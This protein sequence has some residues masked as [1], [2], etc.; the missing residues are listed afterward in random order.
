MK[1]TKI[2]VAAYALVASFGAMAATVC[3][4]TTGVGCDTTGLGTPVDDLALLGLAVAALAA[5]VGIIRRKK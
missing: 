2:L 1:F 3:D 4:P 5:G